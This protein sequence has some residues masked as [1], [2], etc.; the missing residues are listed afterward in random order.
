MSSKRKERNDVRKLEH[1][2]EEFIRDPKITD[3]INKI[4][5]TPTMPLDKSLGARVKIKMKQ[6]N[7]YEKRV[8]MPKGNGIFT[9]LT[10]TDMRT[11]FFDNVAFS[12]TISMDK[13]EKVLSL[14]ERIEKVDNIN[15]IIKLLVSQ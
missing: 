3:L 5:L 13:A 6:G 1:F 4:R 2:T 8:D 7:E 10:E 12:Q 9:P 11:K 15:K 14:I